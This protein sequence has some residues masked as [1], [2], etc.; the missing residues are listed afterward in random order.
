MCGILCVTFKTPLPDFQY[1]L[2]SLAHR[3]PDDQGIWRSEDE[4]VV[5]GHRRLAILDRTHEG[6][7]PMH[8]HQYVISFNG[9]IYN[10]IE[11]REELRQKGYS[12]RT[13]TDTEVLAAALRAWGKNALHKFNGMWAFVSYDCTTGELLV[14]RDR[15]GVKPLFYAKTKDGY[16]F[17]SE[18]KAIFP[19]LPRIE[20]SKHFH[21]CLEHLYEYESTDKCLIEGIARFPAG[22]YAIVSGTTMQTTRYWNTFEHIPTSFPKR[23]EEQVERF[24]ELFLDACRIRMRSDVRLGTSLSGGVDSTAVS[25]AIAHVSRIHAGESRLNPD[26]QNAFVAGFPDTEFDETTYAKEVA[27]FLNI[28]AHFFEIRPPSLESVIEEQWY[29]EEIYPTPSTPMM[30]VYRKMR[31]HDVVVSIDGHGADELLGGYHYEIF[32]AWADANFNIAKIKE[33]HKVYRECFFFNHDEK[34]RKRDFIRFMWGRK[35]ALL[36]KYAGR[37]WAEKVLGLERER[38]LGE[39]NF[40]LYRLY[41]RTV[42]P[43]LLR[44]YDRYSMAS[45][46]EVRMPFLDWRLATF[47]LGLPWTSKIRGGLTKAILR[48]AAAPFSPHQIIYRKSKIGYTAPVH[49][50]M[51]GT[52]QKDVLDLIHSQDFIQSSV[53]NA[54]K[55]HK[56]YL[57]LLIQKNLG[58]KEGF[59]LWRAICPYLWEKAMLRPVRTLVETVTERN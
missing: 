36:G 54:A 40:A 45:G 30:H 35:K 50:W 29:F 41:T 24:R 23:Y 56:T 19:F 32:N 18:M 53:V 49:R 13:E 55:I 34:F 3:G 33:I 12:F 37:T 42:L 9:E 5:L 20:R 4:Q 48:D 25:C 26:W 46:V 47:A 27:R 58:V 17:A 28:P 57:P 8:T 38:R 51:N 31:E 11:L 6:A 59:E 1:A 2:D 21:W 39:F 16:V 15:F 14:A 10:F 52:W 22:H 7:Q 44:N 43:T